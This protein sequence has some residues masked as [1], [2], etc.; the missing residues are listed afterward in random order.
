MVMQRVNLK[1]KFALV[2][3]QWK[4]RIIAQVNDFHIKAVKLNGE[5]VWHSHAETDELFF[6]Q[7][8]ELVIRLRDGEIR[9][10]SGELFV[11]PRGV[12]HCPVANEECEVLLMERAGTLNTGDYGGDRTAP[13]DEWI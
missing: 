5:F 9:L 8:G 10:G 13:H 11:V 3:E 12:E 1:D 2:T 7:R 6:V 4:P